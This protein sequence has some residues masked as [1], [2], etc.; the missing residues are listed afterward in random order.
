MKIKILK[1]LKEMMCPEATQDLKLNTKNRDAS[2]KAEHIN[3]KPLKR[4]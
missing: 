2:I 4:L 3:S 1:K